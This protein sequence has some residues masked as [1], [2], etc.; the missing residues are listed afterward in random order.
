M[1]EPKDTEYVDIL[2]IRPPHEEFETYAKYRIEALAKMGEAD[3][4]DLY[5]EAYE[6]GKEILSQCIGESG[7]DYHKS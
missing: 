5:V 6:L 2:E 4:L 3:K 1:M 7:Y